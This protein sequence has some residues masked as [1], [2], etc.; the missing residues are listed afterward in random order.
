[1]ERPAETNPGIL[2]PPSTESLPVMAQVMDATADAAA[3]SELVPGVGMGGTG[4]V[5]VGGGT[6]WVGGGTVWVDGPV[7]TRGSPKLDPLTAAG[8][9]DAAGGC[10]ASRRS[11]AASTFWSTFA[12][13]MFSHAG[14]SSGG[15]T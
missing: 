8:G 3:V 5:L 9:L 4:A 14:G 12:S 1:M 2:P 11:I 15:W 13:R 6:V 10:T 7:S